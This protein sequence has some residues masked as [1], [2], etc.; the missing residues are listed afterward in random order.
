MIGS[1]CL[2]ELMLLL[3]NRYSRIGRM[4]CRTRLVVA[5]RQPRCDRQDGRACRL[6]LSLGHVRWPRGRSLYI[7][8]LRPCL[9]AGWIPQAECRRLRHQRR[10]SAG[11]VDAPMAASR[12]RMASPPAALL[13]AVHPMTNQSTNE[14]H[15]K[16]VTARPPASAAVPP[17][18][19]EGLRIGWTSRASTASH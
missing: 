16:A 2:T 8:D 6:V 5:A 12:N 11:A 4:H 18:S 15:T 7:G 17:V 13:T 3:L 14:P 10:A 1:I 19:L 9:A